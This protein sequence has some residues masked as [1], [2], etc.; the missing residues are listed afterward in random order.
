MLPK[1]LGAAA[2]VAAL[3][4]SLCGAAQAKETVRALSMF[5]EPVAYTQSFLQFVDKLNAAGE[6]VV[7]IE[8][9]GG[10]E[11]I[12]T[13]D[14]AEALRTGVIDMVYGPGSFYGGLVPETDALVGSNVTPMEKRANG[15]IDL[16]NQIHQDKLNAY[17]LGHPTAA[18]SS[19]ST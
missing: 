6:G 7:Q 4:V 5:P 17:Y 3:T 16:L 13:F 1:R 19:T 8:F 2:G 10:P 9:V 15:G 11:A 18:S 12:P 14:Q